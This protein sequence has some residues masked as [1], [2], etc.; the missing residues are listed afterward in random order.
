MILNIVFIQSERVHVTLWV[1]DPCL[2]FIKLKF[3]VNRLGRL[4]N[5]YISV[6]R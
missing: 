2:F 5:P 4:T 3:K 1:G 6:F